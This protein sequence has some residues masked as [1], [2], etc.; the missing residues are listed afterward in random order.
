MNELFLVSYA[1]LWL[2]VIA[3]A[4]VLLGTLRQLGAIRRQLGPDLPLDT[5]VVV[6]GTDFSEVGWLPANRDGDH[7]VV[8]I[9]PACDICAKVLDG[10]S[11]VIKAY[12]D[13]KAMFVSM[14]TAAESRD[15]LSKFGLGGYEVV[16]DPNGE[17]MAA[18]GI[19]DTPFAVVVDPNGHVR[20]AAVVNSRRQ[21]EVLLEAEAATQE[22]E[23]GVDGSRALD[24]QA[25]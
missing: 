9:S 17:R 21:V 11:F 8:F 16:T 1:V 2:L 7:L 14:G 15:Y 3:L 10:L 22:G 13:M 25:I 5:T 12:P 4:V 18:I 19:H 24:R 6:E 20:R 23:R